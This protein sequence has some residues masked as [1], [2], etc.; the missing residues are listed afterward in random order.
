[1]TF[2]N[3]AH[4][5][6]EF[7]ALEQ[8]LARE[9]AVRRTMMGRPM[10]ALGGKMFACLDRVDMLAVKLGRDSEWHARALAIPGAEVFRPGQTEREFKDWVAIPEDQ[11]AEWERFAGAALEHVR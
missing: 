10:L 5:T 7:D 8:S 1:M 4:A 9:G 3:S 6:A 11:S 2:E